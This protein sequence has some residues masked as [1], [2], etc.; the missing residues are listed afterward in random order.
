MARVKSKTLYYHYGDSWTD[1]AVVWKDSA[2]NPVNITGY[3][4]ALSIRDRTDDTEVL[5]LTQAADDGI[6][7]TGASGKVELSATPTKMTSG[8][9]EEGER[10]NYDWQVKSADGSVKKT[11]L[12]GE[13]WVDEE[14]A[15][16]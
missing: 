5:K 9:L 10:Y 4:S 7:L 2:G 6:T 16:D 11:L 8:D 13:V 1:Y 12:K 3:T 15:D 14:Q